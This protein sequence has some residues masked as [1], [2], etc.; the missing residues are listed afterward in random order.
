[1]FLK[2]HKTP[3]LCFLSE[4]V[5][6]IPALSQKIK[7]TPKSDY[8]EIQSLK[9][10]LRV[11]KKYKSSLSA[12]G[13]EYLDSLCINLDKPKLFCDSFFNVNFLEK[14][15]QQKALTPYLE[16]SCQSILGRTELNQA[17][18]KRCAASMSKDPSLC[19]FAGDHEGVL[20]PRPNCETIGLNLNHSKL[21]ANY[22]DCPARV[23]N[24][25][26]TN[27]TR[28]INH[29]SSSAIPEAGSCQAST[30]A[31]FAQ[32]NQ[33][34][35]DGRFWDAKLC[36][37][38]KIKSTEVCHPVVYGNVKD[39]DLSLPK[40]VEKIL[41]R[42]KGLGN[43]QQC[44]LVTKKQYRPNL[45]EFKSGCQVII[46]IESCYA[47]SCSFDIILNQNNVTHIK[48]KANVS[49]D[50][51]PRS[52]STEN[53][54]QAKLIEKKFR[55]KSKAIL[56][57]SFLKRSFNKYPKGIIHGVACAEDMLP[58]FFS[59]TVINQCSPLPFIVD[60]YKEEDG[61][62]A[63][64]IRTARDSLHAPRLLPWSHLFSALK[65]YQRL[66]PLNIWGL[67]VLH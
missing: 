53:F 9:R 4:Q 33:D 41:Q 39:S 8:R 22:V 60:G 13:I 64:V 66:H 46:D 27:L 37:D 58:E 65:D 14:A 1:S 11:A 30:S 54:A 40:V 55:L 36:Y 45:L 6:S 32:F 48:Q 47:T 19:M 5:K 34:T 3:Y 28:I 26:M 52:F 35:T 50:Y 42:T 7:N 67:N 15:A 2:D 21:R 24:D 23:A 51:F 63:V 12:G 44:R 56:N 38:D 10:Q 25:A 17:D 20:T 16:T 57:V 59:K 61:V 18:Y 62:F 31:V 43:D 29:F 49:F